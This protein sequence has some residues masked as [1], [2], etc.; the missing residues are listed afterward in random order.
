MQPPE[1]GPERVLA[2]LLAE[3]LYERASRFSHGDDGKQWNALDVAV[4]GWWR[5]K[6]QHALARG[7]RLYGLADAPDAIQ[8]LRCG[9]T[10]W[11]AGDIAQRYCG[12][13]KR[14]HEGE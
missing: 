9:L 5:D 8:C 12:W 7:Y 6:A 11:N 10:S 13:C 4:Q 2:E 3:L 14:Y 1:P